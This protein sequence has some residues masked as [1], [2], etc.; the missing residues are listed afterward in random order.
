LEGYFETHEHRVLKDFFKKRHSYFFDKKIVEYV[1]ETNVGS[2]NSIKL[3]DSAKKDLLEE[4]NLSA[5]NKRKNFILKENIIEKSL[6]YNEKEGKQVSEVQKL[7]SSDY[8]KTVQERMKDKG[9]QQGF[10]CLF[11]GSPGTGKTESVYQL[12]KQTGRDIFMVDISDTKSCWFGESEKK[13]KEVFDKYKNYVKNSEITPI[14]LFNEADAVFGKRKDVSSSNVAQTENAIQNI[15]L[16]EM[17][18]FSGIL[19]ATTNLT[20]N[21]DSAFERRFVYKIKFEKPTVL[22]KQKIWQSKLSNL[23][24]DES[25]RL[26]NTFDFS[27]GE[28]D[29]IV[30]KTTINEIIFGNNPQF[31]DLEKLCSDEK[32]TQRPSIGFR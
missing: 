10:S 32:I 21:L 12:A 13:I 26:A 6:F 1:T 11:Y 30:R 19:I 17:E 7:L 15:I 25:L 9:L 8:F 14:L 24:D 2:R 20:D 23:T 16:Q 29:N 27:G 31:S 28:I 18:N 5:K 3:T 22:A 4:L